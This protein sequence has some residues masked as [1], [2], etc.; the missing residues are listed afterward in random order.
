MT[1]DETKDFWNHWDRLIANDDGAAVQAHLAAGR[2]VYYCDDAYPENMVRK[3]PDGH[4][5]LVSINDAGEVAVI[6]EIE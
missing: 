2:P 4:L 3:W 5:E 6:H 1:E